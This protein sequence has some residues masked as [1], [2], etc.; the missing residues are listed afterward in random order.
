MSTMTIEYPDSLPTLS[1]QSVAEFE[2]ESR[3]ALAMKMYELGR[4]S[5][6]QAAR[7]AGIP[8][9]RFLLECPR[10]QVPTVSWDDDEI[11]AE[12]SGLAP[13]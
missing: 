2:Q 9:A 12:F 8:R 10:F 4:W 3:L 11:E 1:N 5:S 7:V 13:R 6:G